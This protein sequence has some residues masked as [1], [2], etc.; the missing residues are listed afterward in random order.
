MAA[1][2][3]HRTFGQLF[4][5]PAANPLGT[6]ESEIRALYWVIYSDYHVDESPTTVETLEE[7][8]L[9][10]FVEPIGALGLMVATEGSKTGVLE[11]T[12][13]HAL[14][15]S[16][17]IQSHADRGTTFGYECEVDGTNAYTFA[18][19][20][21]QL[22]LTPYVNMPRTADRHLT[23]LEGDPAKDMVGP[24]T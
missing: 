23:L 11:L 2:T 6:N 22:G 19:D 15:A 16:R 4:S 5:D 20:R 9:E 21:N 13:G 17:P 8:M 18:F 7:E 1:I 14:Y 24:F 10:D 12:H 3:A